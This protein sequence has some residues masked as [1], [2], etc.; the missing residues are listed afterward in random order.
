MAGEMVGLSSVERR[1]LTERIRN[2]ALFGIDAGS[3]P[4]IYRIA[5]MNMYLHGD[6]GSHIY[7]ADSLDKAFGAVGKSSI[8]YN[9]QLYE[10]RDLICSKGTKFDVILS[11]PPFSLKYTRD[12]PEQAV[13]LN[14]YE[15]S[16]DKDHGK[17]LPSLLS[18][19]MFLE[20]YKD[21]V[22]P[23][24]EI[25]AIIDDSVLS[26]QSYVHVRNYIR[27]NFIIRA[28]ISLP[29]DAFRRA[30]ARVKTSVLILRL[31]AD[32]ETQ[33]EIFM[34][35]AVTLGLEDKVARRIGL[36]A[37]NLER[38]KREEIEQIAERYRQFCLGV[39]GN[40]VVPPG[41][42]CD[43]LDVKFC[44]G[45]RGRRACLWARN[46]LKVIIVSKALKLA[47]GRAR[48]VNDDDEYQFLRV[49][50]GGQ[51]LEGELIIGE[52]CSY[53]VLYEVRDWDI[54]LSN[55][56]VGRGAVGIVPPFH[57]GKFVSAEYTILEAA[58]EEEAVYYASLLRTKEI[59]GDILATTTGMNRGRVRWENIGAVQVPEYRAGNEDIKQIVADLKALWAAHER[60]SKGADS[61]TA[62]VV[63]ELDVDGEEARRRWLAFKPP[64]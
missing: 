12:D 23:D 28:I 37:T 20:R 35:S 36:P 22:A 1:G 29:G 44:I 50:Y 25:L 21:L 54:L 14:Q 30:S 4:A 19:V 53:S 47:S 45:D 31:R 57:A 63:A 6:G 27:N 43:R 3:D 15:M 64:E 10:L 62:R 56:G 49:S 5:R 59:L 46:G 11:N 39:P 16:I 33:G 51:V 9:L 55:M 40:Y 17:V 34:D 24:G 32:H 13:T 2:E 61:H 41:R 18:S 38:E 58:S 52:D 42:L 26:G 8:E 7:H 60:F 48:R